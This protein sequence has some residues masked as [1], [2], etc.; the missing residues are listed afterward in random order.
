MTPKN[1]K[2]SG[3]NSEKRI[4][5]RIS[6]KIMDICKVSQRIAGVASWSLSVGRGVG[7]L[8]P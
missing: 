6:P 4:R 7:R 3:T 2:N 8:T 5:F 1:P